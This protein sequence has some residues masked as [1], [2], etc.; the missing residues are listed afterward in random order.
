[1]TDQDKEN[2]RAFA[3]I[4]AAQRTAY[5]SATNSPMELS[6]ETLEQ[7]AVYYLTNPHAVV[8]SL[9]EDW[10]HSLYKKG[11]VFG[12]AYDEG[13]KTHPMLK[14]FSDLTL[15]QQVEE[16]LFMQTIQALSRLM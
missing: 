6:F 14:S 16:L 9:H 8:S 10:A 7:K 5:L 15:Q 1:M 2:I 12:V 4:A 3:Q 13:K 11:W